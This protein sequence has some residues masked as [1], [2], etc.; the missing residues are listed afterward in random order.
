MATCEIWI[1]KSEF[2]LFSLFFSFCPGKVLK[3][4]FPHVTK[5]TC[6]TLPIT[7]C[8]QCRK[9]TN[10]VFRTASVGSQFLPFS[11]YFYLSQDLESLQNELEEQASGTAAVQEIRQK[12][13]SEVA[14]LQLQ[15]DEE[16][17]S[18]ASSVSEM[19]DKF[20]SE[21]AR[22]REELDQANKVDE[23][24]SPFARSQSTCYF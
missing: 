18:H 21:I 4:L 14:R 5:R 22:L 24:E 3:W 10:V 7:F 17:R 2:A 19:K 8:I 11:S 12:R 23:V 15:L 9:V 13:E 1:L 6:L 20:Q 16:T